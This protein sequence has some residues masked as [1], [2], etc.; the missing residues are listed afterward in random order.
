MWYFIDIYDHLKSSLMVV[1]SRAVWRSKNPGVP[2]KTFEMW[3]FIDRFWIVWVK[4]NSR[5]IGRSEN[6]GVPVLFDG[7]NL[8]HL[9]EIGLTD[10]QKS[11]G[12]MG[13]PAPPGTTGLHSTRAIKEFIILKCLVNSLKD[14]LSKNFIAILP[15]FCA[16]FVCTW[17]HEWCFWA[18]FFSW[19]LLTKLTD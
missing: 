2:I 18:L 9:V 5:A 1:H 6:P 10:L 16:L 19:P 8:P 17:C 14:N 12:V 11:E 7:H 13:T 3:Y 15:I 4:W